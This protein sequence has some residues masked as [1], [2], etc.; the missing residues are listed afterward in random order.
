MPNVDLDPA[1]TADRAAIVMFDALNGYLHPDDPQKE[2]NLT[3]W[4]IRENMQA[5]LKG[6]RANGLMTFYPSG[7][8]AEDGSDSARRLTDTDM[9]LR[10]W[11]DRKPS[12]KPNISHGSEAAKVAAVVAPVEGDKL[13]PKHR[14]SSF[15]Q[16]HLELQLRC[17]GLKTIVIAGGSSDV[18]IVS[19]VFAAR[20]LDFGIVVVRDCCY[21]HRDGNNDF[22]MNR[23]FPRMG[24]VMTAEQAVALM[25][26]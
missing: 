6:A 15:F 8:H 2:A 18:G 16:T 9:E 4:R 20:D 12:T 14:W 3:A 7:D 26:G 19:T 13:I 1:L 17:R 24:R 11:G 5:L 10:P 25:N 22:L 21:S 23:I